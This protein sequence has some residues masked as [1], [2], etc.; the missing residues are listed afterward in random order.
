MAASKTVARVVRLPI[1]R[2]SEMFASAATSGIP[3]AP[4]A[5]AR[6]ICAALRE[7]YRHHP[8]HAEYAEYLAQETRRRQLL[9]AMGRCW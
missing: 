8:G 1:G 9:R 3:W 5:G 7:K 6:R 2:C 4:C